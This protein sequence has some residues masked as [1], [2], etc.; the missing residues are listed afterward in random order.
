MSDDVLLKYQSRFLNLEFKKANF[1]EFIKKNQNFILFAVFFVFYMTI[2]SC[3]VWYKQVTEFDMF[4][5]ADT[6]R[7]FWDLI[8]ITGNHYRIKV[9]PLFLLFCQ[10]LCLFVKGV[11]QNPRVAVLVVEATIASGC[12]VTTKNILDKLMKS[13]PIKWLFV[14]LYGFSFSCMIFGTIPETFIFAGFASSSFWNYCL[15]IENGSEKFS[16]KEISI[17]IFFAL[18]CFGMTITNYVFYMVGLFYICLKRKKEFSKSLKLFFLVNIINLLLIVVFAFVQKLIWKNAPLF[19]TS[20]YDAFFSKGNYEEYRYMNWSF[21]ISKL[22]SFLKQFL[23][24]PLLSAD[25]VQKTVADYYH[26]ILFTGLPS[27]VRI[28]VFLFLIF[29]MFTIA[30]KLVKN[31]ISKN[32]TDIYNFLLI[33]YCGNFALH[34]IYGS[35]EAFMYS[36]HYLFLFVIL[37]A[38]GLD[39]CCERVKKI[40]VYGILVFV[41]LEIANNIIRYLQ[42]TG[43]VLKFLGSTYSRF[44]SG[45]KGFILALAFL[46]VFVVLGKV[47]SQQEKSQNGKIETPYYMPIKV[48]L[49]ATAIIS[50]AIRLTWGSI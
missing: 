17:L 10:P 15:C 42:M 21:S 2:G 3:V 12:V 45:I 32:W 39:G 13:N 28:F 30:K 38:V 1:Y 50:I 34:F 40:S 29:A 5:G 16:K 36:P 33:A 19:F 44:V 8:L 47:F 41:L 11:V 14:I 43:I 23:V 18:L 22:Y 20:L 27:F 35:S 25:M 48:Y 37:F 49:F 31:I 24:Y 6:P 7:V 26:P 46:L 9:H 4:W